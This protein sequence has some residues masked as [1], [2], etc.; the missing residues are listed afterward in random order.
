VLN[1]MIYIAYVRDAGEDTGRLLTIFN[2]LSDRNGNWWILTPLEDTSALPLLSYYA[3]LP[4]R[5]ISA[6]SYLF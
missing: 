6:N 1:H 2:S 5:T 4:G 3:T